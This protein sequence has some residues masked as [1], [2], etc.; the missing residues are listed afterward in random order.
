[1]KA[2][3]LVT[4]S[5]G[6]L[7]ACEAPQ[8]RETDVTEATALELVED[9]RHGEA[10]LEYVALS[11]NAE[12]AV[13]QDLMLEAVAL[14]LGIGRTDDASSLLVELSEQ[15]LAGDLAPRRNLL[16]ADLALRRREP[17]RTHRAA[18]GVPGRTLRARIHREA[19]SA[20]RARL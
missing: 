3:L 7:V 2:I 1:M 12:G 20:A 5:L 18:V 15:T 19:P 16:A 17:D 8:V 6:V 4:I 11:R 9:G 14:L 13:A 10:A